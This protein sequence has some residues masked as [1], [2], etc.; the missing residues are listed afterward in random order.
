DPGLLTVRGRDLL[1]EA[2]VVLYDALVDPRLLG[3][4]QPG[5]TL[6]DVGKTTSEVRSLEPDAAV[7]RG[8]VPRLDSPAAPG[9][10]ATREHSTSQDTINALLVRYGRQG[11]CV[12]RLKGGDPFIF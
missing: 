7:A 8:L 4:T 6:V 3:L 10:A 12:V 11:E 9:A 5:C 1:S 2:D